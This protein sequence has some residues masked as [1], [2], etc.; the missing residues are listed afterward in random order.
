MSIGAGIL[1]VVIG[2]ILRFALNIQ[3]AWIDLNLVGNI[4]MAAGALVFVLGLIF[5]FRRR[6]STTTRRTT[7]GRPDGENVVRRTDRTDDTEL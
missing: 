4:L 1:L 6:R 7:V 5:T 3:L 2:A